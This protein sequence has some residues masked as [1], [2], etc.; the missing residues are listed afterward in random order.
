MPQ[1]PNIVFILADQLRADFLSC[2]GADFVDTPHIDRLAHE[3][4]RYERA[5]SASPICVPARASLLTGLNAIKNGVTSNAQW[6]RPDLAAC[7][8]ATW[9]ET[10]SQRGYYTAGVGKMHFY[11]WDMS[12]GFQYRVAAEDKRWL[13]VRDDYYHFLKENGHRKYHG[14]EHE[15]YRE[16]RGAIVS[17]VPWEYSVD[18]FVG[19]EACRFIENY[20]DESPFAVMVGFPGPHCPYDPTAEYLAQV[21]ESAMPP[22]APRVAENAPSLLRDCIAVNKGE[23]N[24]VDYTEFNEGHKRKIRAHYAALVK[25]IDHEVGRIVAAL[26]DK[27]VL[28]NTVIVFASDHGDYLGDH[29]LIGKGSFYEASI[30][31]PMIVRMPGGEGGREWDGMIELG[32]VTATLLHLAGCQL[33]EYMDSIPLPGLGIE[34]ELRRQVLGLTSGGWML[35]EGDLKLCKYASGETL[36][37]NLAKDPNEQR[38]LIADPAWANEYSRLDREL[39]RQVM[40]SIAVLHGDRR[41]DDTNSLWNSDEYGKEGW[42]RPYPNPLE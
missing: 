31:V 23:W 33:P 17:L 41:L 7:G 32:D 19:M 2:Y 9:P 39:T 21:D 4:I 37:F 5:Y 29:D 36:L 28:D 8:I 35:N 18:H 20:A 16:N 38:N 12:L 14:D 26:A 3:G 40:D 25:Q 22:A 24:G 27:G 13:Q 30:H 6:L 11:P 10:L 1:Q 34:A 15:G 42:R